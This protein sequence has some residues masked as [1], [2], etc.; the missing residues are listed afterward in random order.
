MPV[1][2]AGRVAATL[3]LAVTCGCAPQ[4]GERATYGIVFYCPG[5][6]VDLGDTGVRAG[7]E[8]AGFPGQVAR[9]TW[10]VSMNPAIDQTIRLLALRGA[11]SLAELIT[12]Y[13][14]Q[15]PDCPITIVGL[16]AGTGIAV[17]GL[18]RLEPPYQVDNVILLASSLSHDYD[19]GP[20]LRAVRG[21]IY[22]YYSP[23]DAVLAG[24]MQIA[25]TIDRKFFTAGAGQVG[26][27]SPPG[28]EE[29]IVNIEWHPD[30]EQFGYFGGHT[31]ATNP[32]FVAAEL[33]AHVRARL[34]P[35][36]PATA[37]AID[38]EAVP[39]GA[40]PD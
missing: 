26:L 10:S 4:F 18:E 9:V 24:P 12:A 25:G 36:G 23:N 30:F 1:R 11:D 40:P 16:S 37:L 35:E 3:C 38:R 21:R 7:L 32:A 13:I 28:N 27:R 20:A 34:T 17:W 8:K 29:R 33:A 39:R 19:V 15:C 2:Y 6:G 22:N 14:D 31:D 5:A